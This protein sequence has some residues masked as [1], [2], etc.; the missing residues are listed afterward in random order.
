MPTRARTFGDVL[1]NYYGST[2]VAWAT[3]ANPADLRAAPGTVGL[4]PPGTVVRILDETGREVRAGPD[5]GASSSATSMRFRATPA[6]AARSG[7]A[8]SMCTGDVGHLDGAG[9]LFVDGR[10]D[11]M[12][13]SGGENVFPVEVEKLLSAHPAVR[14]VAAC[15]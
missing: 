12:I 14:E 1:Y 3:I 5:A 8:V 7:S 9:R 15:R 13:V 10:D 6:A 4:P 2:E 11:E